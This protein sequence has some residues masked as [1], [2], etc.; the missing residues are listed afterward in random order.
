LSEEQNRYFEVGIEL[1][2]DHTL[3][4]IQIQVTERAYG[5]DAIGAIAYS[6][7]E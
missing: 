1:L 6:V 7:V 5:D 3:V 4:G 2:V